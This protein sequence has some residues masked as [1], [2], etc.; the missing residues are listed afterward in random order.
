MSADSTLLYVPHEAEILERI[1]ESPG[2]FTLRLKFT[3]PEI[4]AQFHFEPGQFNMLYLYGVGEVAISIVS[5][6]KDPCILDHTIRSVGRVTQAIANMKAG[7]R[8]GV[9]LRLCRSSIILHIAGN[10]LGI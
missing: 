5:D 8:I 10:V 1:Q 6:P 7:D 4:Q 3:D 2:L 9:V